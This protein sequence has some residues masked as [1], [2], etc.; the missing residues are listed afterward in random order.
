MFV[1]FVVFDHCDLAPAVEVRYIADCE[2]ALA[3]GVWRLQL[4]S[5]SAHCDLAL[6]VEAWLCPLRSGACC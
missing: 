3:V 1:G 5:G 6:A 2:L 4:R